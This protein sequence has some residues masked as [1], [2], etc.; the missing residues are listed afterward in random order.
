MISCA[1][2]DMTEEEQPDGTMKMSFKTP[3]LNLEENESKWMPDDLKCDAC[4]IIAHKVYEYLSPKRKRSQ[5]MEMGEKWG[6]HES[7]WF[8]EK[9]QVLFDS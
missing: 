1:L 3:K 7:F 8:F 9:N 2:C 6:W 5:A 4:Y